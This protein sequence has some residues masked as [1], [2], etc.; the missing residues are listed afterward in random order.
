VDDGMGAEAA[1]RAEGRGGRRATAGWVRRRRA[2]RREACG[3]RR[4]TEGGRAAD[5]RLSGRLTRGKKQGEFLVLVSFF[6]V[7]EILGNVFCRT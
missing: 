1:G 5:A 7:V 3:G 4:A 2:E 6:L